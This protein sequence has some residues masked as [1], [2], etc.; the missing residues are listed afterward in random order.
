MSKV[1]EALESAKHFASLSA[2]QMAQDVVEKLRGAITNAEAE[3]TAGQNPMSEETKATPL[4]PDA[5]A[6]LREWDNLFHR[7]GANRRQP[8]TETYFLNDRLRAL[9]DKTLRDQSAKIA[10]QSTKLKANA[11]RITELEAGKTAVFEAWKNQS[12]GQNVLIVKDGLGE[13]QKNAYA[14]ANDWDFVAESRPIPGR[15]PLSGE[16]LERCRVSFES[17]DRSKGPQGSDPE[18][19]EGEIQQMRQAFAQ[20]T[21]M[22]GYTEGSLNTDEL[23]EFIRGRL[24]EKAKPSPEASEL[25]A[26]LEAI[27]Q[28]GIFFPQRK[29]D[30]REKLSRFVPE[31]ADSNATWHLASCTMEL[32]R[33]MEASA[34]VVVGEEPEDSLD[35]RA[36]TNAVVALA[37]VGRIYPPKN[38]HIRPVKRE[39]SVSVADVVSKFQKFCVDHLSGEAN[40]GTPAGLMLD[41]IRAIVP[42]K[43]E[44]PAKVKEAVEAYQR[45]RR[46]FLY[47]DC[48]NRAISE[49]AEKDFIAMLSRLELPELPSGDWLDDVRAIEGPTGAHVDLEK[50]QMVYLCAPPKPAR[51]KSEIAM[52]AMEHRKNPNQ[53]ADWSAQMGAYDAEFLEAKE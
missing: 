26:D 27:Y 39:V 3:L 34:L 4:S 22:I 2:H 5:E 53:D 1:K 41:A 52:L 51:T 23:L 24:L 40:P 7:N 15:E 21:R 8:G 33:R 25:L 11:Q 18:R 43:P 37:K 16:E 28:G 29:N 13:W 44:T 17:R 42:P 46:N 20:L 9:I 48:H 50:G 49:Q 45:L 36:Y 35:Y 47:I 31:N 30:L 14:G 38:P 12:R 19:H 10:E 6:C 32:L